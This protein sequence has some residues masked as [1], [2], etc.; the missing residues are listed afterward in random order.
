MGNTRGT[1]HTPTGIPAGLSKTDPGEYQRLYRIQNRDR[2]NANRKEWLEG[3][4]DETKQKIREG[5]KA[6]RASEAGKASLRATRQRQRQARRDYIQ[7]AKDG[8]CMDCGVEYPHYVMDFHHR[9]P[10]TKSF[11]VASMVG[12]GSASI[13]LIQEEIDKCDLICAN[14][15]RERHHGPE[16]C[17][18]CG[19]DYRNGKP[20]VGCILR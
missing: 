4:S 9:D 19:S 8:P 3:C 14:C 18:V 2:I 7:A 12:R 1:K 20:H 16:V 17:S 11:S 5:G 6:W 15:H 13:D 10:D